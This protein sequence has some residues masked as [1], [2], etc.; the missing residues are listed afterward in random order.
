M[1]RFFLFACT[2]LALWAEEI[3]TTH[4]IQHEGDSLS[5]TATVNAAEVSYIAYT[6]PGENRPI[7]FAFNG[8]PGSS[9][10]WLHLGAFGPRRLITPEEGQSIVAPYRLADNEETLLDLTDIVFIDPVGTGLSPARGELE[11]GKPNPY[12]VRGDI[13]MVGTFIRDFLTKTGRWNSPKY[14]AGE[15]YGAARAAGLAEHLMDQYGIYL[16]GIIFISAAIDLGTLDFG[17]DR[18]LPHL[19]FLPTFATT[20]KYHHR[21]YLQDASIEEVAHNARQFVYHTY[22]PALF[23]QHC[24]DLETI[25]KSVSQMTG[26]PL[27]VIVQ[28][29]GKVSDSLFCQ[30]LLA[31][32]GRRVGRFDGR[33][34]G[35]YQGSFDDP[36]AAL[37]EGIFTGAFHDYLH[38]EL[39]CHNSYQIFS[40]EAI[41][42]WF[43]PDGWGQTNLLHPLRRALTA[44][45]A[46][47]VFVG[48]GYFDLATPFASVEYCFDHLDVPNIQPQFEYY[49]GGHMYYLNPTERV[50]FKQDL[51]RFYTENNG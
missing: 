51:T 44:N 13:E 11:E 6:L 38:K 9:S 22:T 23:C 45:P 33:I 39:N 49:Q 34:T 48:C 3:V 41:E 26:L 24:F 4:S 19:L 8:G 50:K 37:V 12:S 29:R 7:T 18:L 30:Q 2:L 17:H 40:Y 43:F 35:Y 42:K 1:L 28:N 20:A 47:K 5:Y 14:I 46:M 15:S 21:H 10:V 32:E 27:D 31:Q 16:N 36:S 25:Y